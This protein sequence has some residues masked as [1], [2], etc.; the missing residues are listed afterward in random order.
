MSQMTRQE[1][2]QTDLCK[3]AQSAPGIDAETMGASESIKNP[4]DFFYPF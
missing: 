4:E 2:N 3:M 1:R